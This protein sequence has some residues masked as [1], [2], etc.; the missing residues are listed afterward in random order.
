MA[1]YL[2]KSLSASFSRLLQENPDLEGQEL[3]RRAWAE[4]QLKSGVLPNSDLAFWLK[5]YDAK[6]G[7]P[8]RAQSDYEKKYP[9]TI[10]FAEEMRQKE[11]LQ[12][13]RR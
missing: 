9:D 2:P 11:A 5:E 12:S 4:D 8:I 10:T 1:N 13:R 7:K 6:I 3:Y